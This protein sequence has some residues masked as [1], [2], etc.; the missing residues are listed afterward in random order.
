MRI[1]SDASEIRFEKTRQETTR[2]N[3]HLD[4]QLGQPTDDQRT[5]NRELNEQTEER[6]N[7]GEEKSRTK[8]FGKVR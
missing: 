5:T 1:L 6:V 4:K 8:S 7:H 2:T 3:R